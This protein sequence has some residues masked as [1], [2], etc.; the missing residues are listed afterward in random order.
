VDHEARAHGL[1]TP[2]GTVSHTGVGGLTT[3]G[4]F[5]RVARRF[6]LALDNV[7]SV[8][9]V[10]ADGGFHHASKDE[11][12]DLYW[13]VRG[14]GGNFGVVTSFEFQLHPMERQ[15]IGGDL[16]FP[17]AKARDLLTFYA[18]YSLAAPDDLYLDFFISRPPGGAEGVAGFSACYSGPAS[19]AD[20][21]LGPLRKLG[22]P[23]ADNIKPVDYA[24]LQRSTD[25]SDPRAMGTYLKNG[26]TSEITPKLITTILDRLEGHP[27]RSTEVYFQHSGGAIGRVATEAT[28]FAHRYSKHNMMAIIAWAA[29][30]D[31]APHIKWARQYW[32]TLEPFTRGVYVNH[33]GDADAAG[34]AN[35]IYR[36]NY[37]RLVAIK[38]KYDPG[39]LFRLNANVAPKA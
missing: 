18:D 11:N 22:T 26:F 5:G 7:T 21:V 24:A 10:T 6:G 12:E 32:T 13:G 16:A 9:V 23:L 31:S 2:L 38:N 29:G 17:I 39:N 28:A 27:A 8:D 15:V 35:A 34:A 30:G 25:V 1:V 14:G 37:R 33:E 4:G 19:G 3:G 20:R 36:E